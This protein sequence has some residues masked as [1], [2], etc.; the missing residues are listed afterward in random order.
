MTE[1][2]DP[3]CEHQT[4]NTYD[5]AEKA[6]AVVKRPGFWRL[7]SR[8]PAQWSCSK[9]V[10]SLVSSLSKQSARRARVTWLDR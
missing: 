2:S 8:W 1:R 4:M 5:C 6:A 10:E 3:L 9:H 7:N